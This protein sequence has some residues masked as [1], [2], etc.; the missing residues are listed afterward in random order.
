MKRALRV[1]DLVCLRGAATHP[2]D[3]ALHGHI[4]CKVVDRYSTGKRMALILIVPWMKVL[5]PVYWLS[6]VWLATGAGER[7]HARMAK[8]REEIEAEKSAARRARKRRTKTRRT[9]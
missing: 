3:F 1:D 9:K 7:K 6:E 8:M 5:R 4:P 2:A